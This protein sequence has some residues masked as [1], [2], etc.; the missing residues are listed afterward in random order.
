MSCLLSTRLV[1]KKYAGETI[2]NNVSL[3]LNQGEILTISGQSGSGKTTLIRIIS[4]LTGFN[5]G[6][7]SIDDNLI[8]FDSKYPK[9]LL[10]RIG[11]VFQDLNLFPHMT[12]LQ[13][14]SLA[15]KVVKKLNSAAANELS[16]EFLN[17]FGLQS[18]HTS[19]PN[20]LSGG[21]KQ[22][23]AIARAM[24]MKPLV[25][26]LDEPT[27]SLDPKS[28]QGL[29]LLIR[30]LAEGGMPILVAT[31]NMVFAAEIG[32]KFGVL[33]NGILKVSDSSKILSEMKGE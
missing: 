30:E 1:E 24:V 5:A 7:I 4:G 29:Q 20:Q 27:S 11:V 13:N 31:H 18:K 15:L 3:S 23:V 9:H 17:R 33:N 19:Y 28:I 12:A 14:V 6:E 25:L 10:G 21:E 16:A 8:G 26:L 32:D 2:L 22:R